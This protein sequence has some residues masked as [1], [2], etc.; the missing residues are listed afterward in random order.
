MVMKNY[1]ID[2]VDPHGQHRSTNRLAMNGVKAL[3]EF[4][5]PHLKVKGVTENAEIRGTV[6]DGMVYWNNDNRITIQDE[7]RLI[8]WQRQA[9]MQH[10]LDELRMRQ[11][12]QQQ[13]VFANQSVSAAMLGVANSLI[14]SSPSG[15][16]GGW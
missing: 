15:G 8:A 4:K 14:G 6:N 1:R 3:S 2:Y 13:N 5:E 7:E 10:D 12:A 11:Q 16:L 9:M